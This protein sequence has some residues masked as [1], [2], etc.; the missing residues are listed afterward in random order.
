MPL[1]DNAVLCAVMSALKK[2]DKMTVIEIVKKYLEENG[3]EGLVHADGECG[4]ELDDL[5]PCDEW[6][7]QG[8]EPGY[9][10]KCECGEGCNFHIA[11]QKSV[12]S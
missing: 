1:S 6:F 8:C 2:E 3:Y 10:V 4:C 12:R 11:T 9:K 7:C 5:A